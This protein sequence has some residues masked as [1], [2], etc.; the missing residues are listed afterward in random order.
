MPFKL[1]SYGLR[2]RG[3]ALRRRHRAK[4]HRGYIGAKQPSRGRATLEGKSLCLRDAF[5]LTSCQPRLGTV[6]RPGGLGEIQAVAYDP[7]TVNAGVRSQVT[8][9]C[10]LDC[11]SSR[12][13]PSPDSVLCDSDFDSE[14]VFRAQ[15]IPGV[16]AAYSESES[17]LQVC[18]VIIRVDPY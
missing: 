18:T 11:I 1:G 4:Q 13:I 16:S 14:S 2:V 5:R 7:V 10:A 17:V 6:T 12:V 9:A 3:E 8:A 15:V